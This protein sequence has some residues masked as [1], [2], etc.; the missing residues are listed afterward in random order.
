MTELEVS[1]SQDFA[2]TFTEALGIPAAAG[3]LFA[4]LLLSGQPLSQAE[5]RAALSLSEGSVSEGL[6]LLTVDGLVERA[7]DPRARPA[8]FKIRDDAWAGC[9]RHTLETVEALRA[10]AVRTLDLVDD[11]G[12]SEVARLRLDGMRLMYETLAEELPAV[13]QRAV[14]AAA[15]PAPRASARGTRK[16]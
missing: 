9:A 5:L 3:R 15:R 11:Q 14:D 16:R 8:Y 10:L 1:I 7:G 6:R 12:G 2:Q 4:A 13:L